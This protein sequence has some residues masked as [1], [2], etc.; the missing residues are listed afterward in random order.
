MKL[1]RLQVLS[2]AGRIR[3][4]AKKQKNVGQKGLGGFWPPWKELL[5]IIVGEMRF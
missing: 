4:N 1:L 2:E 5:D 3:R